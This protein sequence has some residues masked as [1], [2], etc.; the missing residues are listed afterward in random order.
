MILTQ[1]KNLR[2]YWKFFLCANAFKS[3]KQLEFIFQKFSGFFFICFLE[4]RAKPSCGW[5]KVTSRSNVAATPTIRHPGAPKLGTQL[6]FM[7][8]SGRHTHFQDPSSFITPKSV[9]NRSKQLKSVISVITNKS[10]ISRFSQID[11]QST[12]CVPISSRP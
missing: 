5:Y 1:E 6:I 11:F 8:S 10:I 7:S 9:I 4:G 2:G 3:Y 12:R